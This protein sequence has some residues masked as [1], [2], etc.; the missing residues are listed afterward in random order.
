MYMYS[1]CYVFTDVYYPAE[2]YLSDETP[3]INM[4]M[5]VPAK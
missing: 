3:F 2:I 1:K 4:H 5:H